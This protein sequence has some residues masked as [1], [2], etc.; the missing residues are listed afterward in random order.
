MSHN[1]RAEW[2]QEIGLAGTKLTKPLPKLCCGQRYEC[3]VQI[4]SPLRPLKN[5]LIID[6]NKAG[7][8]TVLDECVQQIVLELHAS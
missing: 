7:V 6:E 5:T 1:K 3:D 8:T 2:K 4:L